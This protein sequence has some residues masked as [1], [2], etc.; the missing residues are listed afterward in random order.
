MEEVGEHSD[1]SRS[2]NN[3]FVYGLHN[4]DRWFKGPNNR[5]GWSYDGFD[6]DPFC[7]LFRFWVDGPLY[8]GFSGQRPF[9]YS[10]DDATKKVVIE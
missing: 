7:R 3:N 2:S 9:L 4:G 6:N 8:N 1:N 5:F 10:R